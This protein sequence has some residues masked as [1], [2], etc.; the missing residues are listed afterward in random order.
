MSRIYDIDRIVE[1]VVTL[2][3]LPVTVAQIMHLVDDPLS[4]LSLVSKAISAD[5]PLAIKT[6]RLVNTAYYGL[7]QKVSTIEHAVV[8]L[9]TKVI[10]N[11]AFTAGTLD[12]MKD[13]V[14][15]YFRHSVACGVAMRTLAMS[16][17]GRLP[18]ESPEEAFVYGLLH[19]IGKVLFDKFLPEEAEEVRR[20]V[21][22][23]HIPT[24]E[25]EKR[26]IG[27]D[28]S[29]LGSIL[30]QK[31]KLSDSLVNAINGHHDV[32]RCH[33]DKDALLAA[34]T[35]IADLIC[36]RCGIASDDGPVNV[37]PEAWEKSLLSSREIPHIM[38]L[39]FT[40]LP[41]VEELIGASQA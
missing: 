41:S 12:I 38:D 9:G 16:G 4:P 23:E 30:A 29:E 31:W 33:D 34:T 2:P 18:I 24:Y 3:S 35:G 32:G 21:A 28:H 6:L 11:L 19:D 13:G 36:A 22:A 37:S 25:A 1:E 14:D 27:V 40:E 26:I 15:G 5:P 7:R 17:E 8:L 39:F 20:A 10:K